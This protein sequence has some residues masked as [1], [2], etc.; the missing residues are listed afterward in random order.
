VEALD[1]EISH[2]EFFLTK[3]VVEPLEW[4]DAALLAHGGQ[5]NRCLWG[6]PSTSLMGPDLEPLTIAA[7]QLELLQAFEAAPAGT[8]LGEL[9]IAMANDE[10]LRLARQLIAERL[11]LPVRP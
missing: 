4:T 7:A 11:L 1:P 10:R 8:P 3:G 5:R 2:F 9:V 6:W